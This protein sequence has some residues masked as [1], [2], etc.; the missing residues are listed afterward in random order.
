LIVGFVR[1]RTKRIFTVS[2]VGSNS[3]FERSLNAME[4][5]TAAQI[6][7]LGDKLITEIRSLRT[8]NRE[9]FRILHEH[10]NGITELERA[11]TA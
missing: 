9:C 1:R 4:Q 3:I 2:H 8:A 5:R 6:A 11:R 7:A 10:E